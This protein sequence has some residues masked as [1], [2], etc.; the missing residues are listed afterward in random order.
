MSS[1]CFNGP[2]LQFSNK[3]RPAD[4]IKLLATIGSLPTVAAGLGIFNTCISHLTSDEDEQ[5][6]VIGQIMLLCPNLCWVRF[7]TSSVARLNRLCDVLKVSSTTWPLLLDLAWYSVPGQ[8]GGSNSTMTGNDLSWLLQRTPN[9]RRID[10]HNVF[11]DSALALPSTV[12]ALV[13]YLGGVSLL[14]RLLQSKESIRLKS[15][16]LW[17]S[18]PLQ[19]TVDVLQLALDS[20]SPSEEMSTLF[21]VR[22]L[23]LGKIGSAFPLELPCTQSL[24]KHCTNLREL[25]LYLR[26]P[27]SGAPFRQLETLPS[28][29][30]RRLQVLVL[31]PLFW[32]IGVRD[33]RG[34]QLIQ[35]LKRGILN[36]HMSMLRELIVFRIRDDGRTGGVGSAF[37]RFGAAHR[38]SV[39]LINQDLWDRSPTGSFRA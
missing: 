34:T 29:I 4:N 32:T 6:R 27:G 23:I 13:G 17:G 14:A 1:Q 38:I 16:T 35:H 24:V 33:S 31:H 25:V 20:C 9:L 21:N 12:R 8:W 22:T 30:S 37:R 26:R 36:G 18:D 5:L 2:P 3:F 15:I 7:Q 39:R 28:M 19:E 11:L 10:L